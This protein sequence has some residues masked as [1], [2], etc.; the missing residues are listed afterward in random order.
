MV[1]PTRANKM[2]RIRPSLGDDRMGSN[3]GPGAPR[4][5]LLPLLIGLIAIG[6]VAMKGCQQ[7]PFGRRQVV[8]LNSQEEAALG[9]QAFQKVL[10]E[11]TVVSNG[12]IVRAVDRV[13]KRLEASAANPDVLQ[14]LRLRPQEFDWEIKVIRSD[15]VNAFCLPGGKVVVYTG[16]V[17]IAKTE[18]GL[19]TVM[20]HEIGHAL[21]HHGAERMAQ[22]QMVAIGQQSVAG[23]LSDMDPRN[24]RAVL[25]LLGAGS[26][27][28]FLLPFSRKHESEADHIG[29]LLMAGAGYDPHQASA[30][31]GR[32][33][34]MAGS[35]KASE[36]MST[37][38]SHEHRARDL[39]AWLPEA[40]PLYRASKKAPDG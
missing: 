32:M 21:A 39:E 40:L 23:S 1:G 27:V 6:A 4:L 38:P 13:G 17:P 31:W 18:A 5:H 8:A 26:Q 33:E 16:I 12:D 35:R 36:F 11:S 3:D 29:L 34:E 28:G 15:Q 22:Q 20:G 30:F 19:A 24:Q 25:G 14:A 7:G 2:T 10:A 9:A 37:H